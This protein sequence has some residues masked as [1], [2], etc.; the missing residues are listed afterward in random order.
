MKKRKA[1]TLVELLVVIAIIGILIG[2]LLPAVQ[3]VRSAAR[4]SVCMNNIRQLVLATHNYES[5]HQHFPSANGDGWPTAESWF[6]T[7]NYSTNEV[8]IVG[9]TLSPFIE[10]NVGVGRCPDMT[11]PVQFLYG[12][13]TGGYGYNQN[14]GA[15]VYEAANGWAPRE[16]ERGFRD[17]QRTGTTRVIVFADAARIQLPWP[18][19]PELK[20]TENFFLQ[21]PEWD[22][23]DPA[24]SVH[25]R[26]T[27]GLAVVGFL[28][29]HA[30]TSVWKNNQVF[31]ASWTADA[32]EM[33]R[34][35]KIDY[36]VTLNDLNNDIQSIR[37]Q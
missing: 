28:D 19:D 30:E 10:N 36:L 17:F 24:P 9:G 18:G 27:G 13:E 8:T 3:M 32:Q 26:H 7:I 12:G 22:F 5:A 20:I 31:P 14:L 11:E 33:A 29:G 6:G 35:N 16:I 23:F 1:F 34:E 15:T 25:F 4:R 2:M 37:Y 21:G